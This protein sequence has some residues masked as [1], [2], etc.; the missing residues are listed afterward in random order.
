MS[1]EQGKRT[2]RVHTREFKA[3]T[4]KLVK[5]GGRGISELARELGLADSLVRARV[6]E[7]DV[8]SVQGPG[9]RTDQRREGRAFAPAEGGERPPD[10]AGNP[11]KG[12]PSSPK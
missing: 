9:E 4:V 2:R 12:P 8:D 1:R 10:G 5:A 11:K 7:G 6:R 3:E